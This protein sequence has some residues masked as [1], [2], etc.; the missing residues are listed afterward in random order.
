MEDP[1]LRR[2]IHKTSPPSLD[3]LSTLSGRDL[4]T[5]DR[6]ESV[7]RGV[8]AFPPGFS[9]ERIRVRANINVELIKKS[10]F[11]FA[12]VLHK[13]KP[14]SYIYN[15]MQ[16]IASLNCRVL[17]AANFHRIK[18]TEV[19]PIYQRLRKQ[20]PVYIYFFFIKGTKDQYGKILRIA[21]SDVDKITVTNAAVRI[22]VRARVLSPRNLSHAHS[23]AA[24]RM[25]ERRRQSAGIIYSSVRWARLI[26]LLSGAAAWPR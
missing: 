25:G 12:K 10:R 3:S 26:S 17:S 23:R 8:S 13:M 7:T 19:D 15:I 11:Q 24:A 9:E 4:G 2:E 16:R 22:V 6:R 14:F 1:P 5:L 20:S 21:I 18:N